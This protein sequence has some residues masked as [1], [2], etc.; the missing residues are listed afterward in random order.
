LKQIYQLLFVLLILLCLF[1]SL[2]AEEIDLSYWQKAVETAAVHKCMIPSEVIQTEC[3]FD[4]NEKLVEKTR[5]HLTVFEDSN[6]T[7]DIKLISHMLNNEDKSKAFEKELQENKQDIL[8]AIREGGL[9]TGEIQKH[10]AFT[11]LKVNDNQA[12]YLL[13]LNSDGIELKGTVITDIEKGY[14]ISTELI[15][16]M[17]KEDSV[18]IRNFKQTMTYEYNGKKWYPIKMVEVME[19]DVKSLFSPFK[20]SVSKQVSLDHHFCHLPFK[21]R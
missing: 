8:T 7:L 21:N 3:I 12:T 16:E 4:R 10:L 9:F 15:S 11:N 6:N 17:M 19:I 20:G 18:T 13:T 2:S 14:A 5:T 1:T